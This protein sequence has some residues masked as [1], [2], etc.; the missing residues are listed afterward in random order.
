MAI[1]LG[2]FLPL[3]WIALTIAKLFFWIPIQ[4]VEQFL[5]WPLLWLVLGAGLVSWLLDGVR[6]RL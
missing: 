6:S 5:T 3:V 2:L 4:N 1:A